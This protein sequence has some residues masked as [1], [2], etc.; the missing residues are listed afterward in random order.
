MLRSMKSARASLVTSGTALLCL[1][2]LAV[3]SFA[4]A[5][6]ASGSSERRIL[7]RSVT[8]STDAVP[9]TRALVR[10][11]LTGSP[12]NDG[13]W[14]IVLFDP[15]LED[16]TRRALLERIG[17]RVGPPV[18]RHARLAELPSGTA[19]TLA[20]TDGVEWVGRFQPG[21][22]LAPELLE[23]LDA[24]SDTPIE[25][26]LSLAPGAD[27]KDVDT[28]LRATG[29]EVASLWSEGALVEAP[30]AASLVALAK[31]EDVL[32]LEPYEK[33]TLFNN[34]SR[35]ITQSGEI[36]N[37]SVHARNV[38]GSGQIVAVM[39]SGID[40]QHCCFDAF[41]K[42]VDNR[43]WGGGQLGALCGGDHGTH[44][45]GTVACDNSGDQDGLAP[46]AQLIMQD[47]QSGSS[48]ACLF[49]SVS[50]PSPLSDAWSDARSRGAFIHT[51]SWGG[52]G[53][54]YG[55]SARAIDKFMW[56]NPDFLILYAAG[57]SGSR[58]SSLGSYSNA[59]N[60]ITVG[61]TRNGSSFEDM[62][63]AS[64]RGPTGDG[65]MEPDLLAPAQGV[66]SARNS[67][68]PSCGFTTYSGTSMATPA[69]AGSA[70]LVREY[71][72][73]GFYPSGRANAADAI[74]P[75]AA[76]MKAT[77]LA[78]TRNML[79]T[80]TRGDRP[81]NDQGFGRTTVDDALWFDDETTDARLQL[82]DDLD[83]DTGF[84]TAGQEDVFELRPTGTA[85]LKIMLT[86]TDAP[87]LSGAARALINDL[88]LEVTTADGKTYLGNR[89]FEGG[90]TKLTST[91][92]D[93]LNNKEGVFFEAAYPGPVTVRV[94]ASEI[95][96]VELRAQDYAL[97][98][99][100]PLDPL[101][102]ESLPEGVGN[103]LFVTLEGEDLAFQWADR[104]ATSYTVYRGET[105]SFLRDS[106]DP[107]ASDVQDEDG[108][109]DGVQW[110]DEGAAGTG[111]PA[112]YFY[113]VSS[114]NAC[115][116][117]SS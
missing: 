5:D 36:G 14:A 6:D 42:I 72:T 91:D 51:N 90:W 80:G 44:V 103:S 11:S 105:G 16:S 60:S 83:M 100:G 30:S 108:A 66:T 12:L 95:G 43:A 13:G 75:S 71:F 92:P 76:L 78:S 85:P 23:M 33:P 110:R 47:I 58:S 109:S 62:Y 21:M 9:D 74:T 97:V 40:P 84:T 65:R 46:D 27:L 3:S 86:W 53:N 50:P 89:G 4:W 113:F 10:P 73:D 17:A 69:A 68:N 64:S 39:D 31:I 99:V 18:P 24:P 67:N 116:Q 54:G 111:T 29:S 106:P 115:G 37:D 55:G 45:S 34:S 56:E 82:L 93:T 70:A 61:G 101:C 28:A 96:D 49:G 8:F 87:A 81:N 25:L 114:T 59:K 79:G 2:C 7:L 1:S 32:H 38:R 117:L 15:R 88:D 107:Y 48:F 94:R 104:A 98:A 19:R 52:G 20:S 26:R 35:G 57:N 63:G 77:L 22:R 41:S 112:A 102:T